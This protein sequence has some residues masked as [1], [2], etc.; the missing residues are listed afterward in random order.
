MK[1]YVRKPAEGE[2]LGPFSIEEISAQ[3]AC[4]ELSIDFEACEATG[5]TYGQLKRKA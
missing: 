1:I 4:G 2:I 3:V 5:Q